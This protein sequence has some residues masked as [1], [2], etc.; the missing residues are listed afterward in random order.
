MSGLRDEAMQATGTCDANSAWSR[1]AAGWGH[2]QEEVF[3]SA[4]TNS[5]PRKSR[6]CR[7]HTWYSGL[8]TVE[9]LKDMAFLC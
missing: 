2:M 4:E 7:L 8:S 1:Q 6:A 3:V 5:L 9:M